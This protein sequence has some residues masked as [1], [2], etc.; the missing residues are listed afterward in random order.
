MCLGFVGLIGNVIVIILMARNLHQLPS[1]MKGVKKTKLNAIMIMNLAI[2]D[3]LV[4]VG[5]SH[6]Q[7]DYN[8]HE[9]L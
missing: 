9:N 4:S 6:T 7:V 1:K 8:D 2:S 3:L 5:D